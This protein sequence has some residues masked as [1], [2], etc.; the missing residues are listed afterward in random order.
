MILDF[1]PCWVAAYSLPTPHVSPNS[2]YTKYMLSDA[3]QAFQDC[4]HRQAMRDNACR[5]GI[6]CI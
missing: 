4:H 1:F 6:I 2:R 3:D 5:V